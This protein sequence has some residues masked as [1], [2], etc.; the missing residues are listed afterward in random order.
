MCVRT[1]VPTLIGCHIL[2]SHQHSES[3]SPP[4]PCVAARATAVLQQRLQ[5]QISTRCKASV[6]RWF[7]TLPA[8]TNTQPRRW[9]LVNRCVQVARAKFWDAVGDLSLHPFYI[10]FTLYCERRTFAISQGHGHLFVFKLLSCVIFVILREL[11]R[12]EGTQAHLSLWTHSFSP[13]LS[14]VISL[15][16]FIYISLCLCSCKMVFGIVINTHRQ[17][18]VE[19]DVCFH[20]AGQWRV[21]FLSVYLHLSLS[22]YLTRTLRDKGQHAHIFCTG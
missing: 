16:L 9:R 21:G 15:F 6:M 20:T 10:C 7:I 12:L 8:L 18:Q 17:T 2:N 19:C 5:W 3:L 1:S 14:L 11:W 13:S 22:H 4:Q